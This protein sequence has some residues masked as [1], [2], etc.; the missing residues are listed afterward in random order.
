MYEYA[1][2]NIYDFIN[3]NV[4][5]YI[6]KYVYSYIYINSYISF[7]YTQTKLIDLVNNKH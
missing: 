4:S 3:R 2:V 7:A 5:I 6:H 1:Y